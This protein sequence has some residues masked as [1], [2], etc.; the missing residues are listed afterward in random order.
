M[1]ICLANSPHKSKAR[2]N[3][4]N[5]TFLI[6]LVNITESVYLLITKKDMLATIKGYYERK[7]NA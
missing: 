1:K 6:R 3:F 7:D 4:T 5:T 2:L